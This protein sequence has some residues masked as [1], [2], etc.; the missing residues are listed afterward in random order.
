VRNDVKA[1][2]R[3]LRMAWADPPPKEPSPPPRHALGSFPTDLQCASRLSITAWGISTRFQSGGARRAAREGQVTSDPARVAGADRVVFRARARC[4]LHA[5]DGC[6][7]TAS[8]RSSTRP[9]PAV[10]GN[11]HRLQMLFERSDEGGVAGLAFLPGAVRCFPAEAM[12][13]DKAATQGF[14]TSAEPREA[15]RAAPP[16]VGIEDGSRLLF[17]RTVLSADGGGALIRGTTDYAS[18]FT[19]AV[20]RDNIFAYSSSGKAIFGPAVT[21]Q[22][23]QL[24][25]LNFPSAFRFAGLALFPDQC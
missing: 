12:V 7:W 2:A 6:A 15:G 10:S 19:C 17:C 25:S 9:Q 16:V 21:R 22:L 14:L 18:P 11:L 23:P 8:R 20:A 13:D 4:R 24:E 1:F 5:R 3:A